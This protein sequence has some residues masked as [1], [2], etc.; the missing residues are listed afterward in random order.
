MKFLIFRQK[1]KNQQHTNSNKNTADQNKTALSAK[2]E[3]LKWLIRNKPI[4]YESEFLYFTLLGVVCQLFIL[5]LLI[6]YDLG[7]L[8]QIFRS[9]L[10]RN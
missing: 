8:L 3:P 7:F 5:F 6:Q 4:S 2:S 1:K 10:N 9:D